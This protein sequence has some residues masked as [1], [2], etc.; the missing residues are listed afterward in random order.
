MSGDKL[1]VMQVVDILK[2]IP[3]KKFR[4][5]DLAFEVMD[6]DGKV[7]MAK[8]ME[9]QQDL[10]LAVTEVKQYIHDAGN[11]KY[12]LTHIN[13]KASYDDLEDDD[14]TED[15]PTEDDTLEDEE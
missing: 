7:D 15:D 9:R 8:A 11:I 3:A 12:K 13:K 6:K 10:N 14:F 2:G 5:T 1:T 4:I